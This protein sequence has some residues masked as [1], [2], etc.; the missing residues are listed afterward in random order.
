MSLN[1]QIVYIVGLLGYNLHF[2]KFILQKFTDR[3]T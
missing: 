3:N 1:I 2:P